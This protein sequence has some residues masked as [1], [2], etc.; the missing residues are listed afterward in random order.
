MKVVGKEIRKQ[1]KN[2]VKFTNTQLASIRVIFEIKLISVLL[3]ILYCQKNIF[4]NFLRSNSEN[5]FVKQD[6]SIVSVTV[7]LVLTIA[8]E[9]GNLLERFLEIV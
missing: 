4:K 7:D 9:A 8:K 6:Q 2:K 3:T 5:F 1:R